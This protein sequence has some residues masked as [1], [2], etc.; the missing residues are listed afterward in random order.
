MTQTTTRA[1][2]FHILANVLTRYATP[3]VFPEQPLLR[4]ILCV[5][6]GA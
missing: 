4:E 1:D 3:H 5:V 2:V 6:S